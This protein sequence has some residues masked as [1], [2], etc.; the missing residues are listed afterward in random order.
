MNF[1]FL[2]LFQFFLEITIIL[3]FSTYLLI[4]YP[5]FANSCLSALF[6]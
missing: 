3:E 6:P 1:H 2:F 5:Y 4:Q